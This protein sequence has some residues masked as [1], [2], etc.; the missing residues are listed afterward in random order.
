VRNLL[1]LAYSTTSTLASALPLQPLPRLTPNLVRR[2]LIP[3]SYFVFLLGF[4]ISGAVFFRGKPFDAKQAIIS[5]LESTDDNPHGY[6]ASAVGMAISA[7]LLAPA[8][9][10]FYRSLQR[11]RPYLARAGAAMFAIGLGAAIAIGF[12]APF[13]HGYSDLHVRLAFAAFIGISG[14]TL[15]HLIAARS[16]QVLI[17][18]QSAV[19]IFLVY[20]YLR[21]DYF[22]DDSHLLT[23]LAFWE[24][25]LCLDCGIALW[26]L[27]SAIRDEAN[28][29]ETRV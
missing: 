12:L 20:L 16:G 9:V 8:A 23:S 13:T 21:T 19:L 3:A 26:R 7:V 14:G 17:A 4:V 15:L 10:V 6:G 27:A 1:S 5:D 2:V 28:G 18:V 24:W 29:L 25:M 11:A 22:F